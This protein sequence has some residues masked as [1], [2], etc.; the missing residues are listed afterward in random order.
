MTFVFADTR[1]EVDGSTTEIGARWIERDFGNARIG[2][3][4]DNAATRIRKSKVFV[5][6]HERMGRFTTVRYNHRPKLGGLFCS[7]RIPV[8]FPAGHRND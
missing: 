8:K 3:R 6:A 1:T 5:N 2:E 4:I 7:R